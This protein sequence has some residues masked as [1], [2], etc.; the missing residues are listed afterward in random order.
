LYAEQLERIQRVLAGA[1]RQFVPLTERDDLRE[2]LVAIVSGNER[3]SPAE[4]AEIYREQFWLR[5]RDALWADYPGLR[6]LLGEDAFEAML[7]AYLL[8]RPPDSW[9]LRDLG[10]HIVAFADGY[11]S[12]APEVAA[13]ARDMARFE[14]AFV[15]VWDGPEATPIDLAAV[16]AV[17]PAAWPGARIVLHAAMQLLPLMHPVHTIRT[18]LRSG[19]DA[20]RELPC[21]PIFVV[22]WRG[23]DKKVHYRAIPAA[24]HALL[25]SLRSGRTLGE[26]C[27]AAAAVATQPEKLGAS[28]SGWFRR[29]TERGWITAIEV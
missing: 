22:L 24:E 28:I 9:T 13:V 2:E 27:E 7:R 1:F 5:H 16:E 6:H 26:A 11:D 17:A 3:L 4:Q 15:D 10:N 8:A 25:A 14:L 12:F 21:A 20:P 18:K 23:K 19:E 29:W